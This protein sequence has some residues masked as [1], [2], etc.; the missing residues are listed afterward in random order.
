MRDHIRGVRKHPA[1]LECLVVE[2]IN[3][4]ASFVSFVMK[5]YREGGPSRQHRNTQGSSR[6]STA[7]GAKAT[8][9]S[10]ATC[11]SCRADANQ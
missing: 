8:C 6:E 10:L 3:D 7:A 4:L 2:I 1:M 9:I 11:I 5:N